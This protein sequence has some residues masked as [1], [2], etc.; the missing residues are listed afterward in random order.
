MDIYNS[1]LIRHTFKDTVKNRALP[2]LYGGSIEIK[3]ITIKNNNI[4]SLHNAQ[5]FFSPLKT[6]NIILDRV[7]L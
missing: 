2:C 6:Y 3:L 5:Y 4:W 7:G 1:F